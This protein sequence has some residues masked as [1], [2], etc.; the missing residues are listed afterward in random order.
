MGILPNIE[1]TPKNTMNILFF[2]IISLLLHPSTS[3]AANWERSDVSLYYGNGYKLAPQEQTTLR[4]E[5]ADGW[6]YGDNYIFMDTFNT[7][8]HRTY[9]FGV[10]RP[11]ISL[12]KTS[13]HSLSYGPIQDVFITSEIDAANGYRA[14]DVGLGLSLSFPGFIYENFDIYLHKIP[15]IKGYGYHIHGAY[16]IPF[17]IKKC[18]F[19]HGFNLDYYSLQGPSNNNVAPSFLFQPELALDLGHFWNN[20]DHYYFGIRYYY[21]HNVAGFTNVN[22]SIPEVMFR[23]FF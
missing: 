18:R 19:E 1:C 9:L 14:Y 3:L 7:V 20:S 16:M 17:T 8:S 15:D 6:A 13:Q 21:W 23:W 5:H 11:R 22:F 2:F 10:F 4:I 12:S